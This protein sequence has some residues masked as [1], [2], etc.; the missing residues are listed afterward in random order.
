MKI[1][2]GFRLFTIVLAV[3]FGGAVRGAAAAPKAPSSLV[4]PIV[5]DLAP[6]PGNPR[7]SEGA[8][9]ELKNGRILFV[10]SRFV[11]TSFSDEAKAR[12]AAR[13]S[14]DGGE[15]TPSSRPLRRMM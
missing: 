4:A 6:G 5:L 9:L 3:A 13:H 1:P 14:T 10:Y 12:L 11:G 8:F 2:S 15:P 7:N